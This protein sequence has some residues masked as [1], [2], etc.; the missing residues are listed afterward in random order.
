MQSSLPIQFAVYKYPIVAKEEG[1]H[2]FLPI[3]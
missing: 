3:Y 2:N 1:K